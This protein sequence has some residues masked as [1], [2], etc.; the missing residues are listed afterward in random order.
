LTREVQKG[1]NQLNFDI[2]GADLAADGAGATS[3]NPQQ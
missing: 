3:Q 2:K 1:S